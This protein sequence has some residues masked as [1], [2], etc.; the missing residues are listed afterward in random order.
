MFNN[1]RFGL[2]KWLAGNTAI[3]LNVGV[4]DGVV[5][6]PSHEMGLVSNCTFDHAPFEYLDLT[7]IKG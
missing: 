7:R 3:M 6:L 1:V 5:T 2:I 4:K